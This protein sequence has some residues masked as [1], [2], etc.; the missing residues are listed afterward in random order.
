[1]NKFLKLM[2]ILTQKKKF[3]EKFGKTDPFMPNK[4]KALSNASS[5]DL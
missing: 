3:L 5:L 1:M 2:R 4:I